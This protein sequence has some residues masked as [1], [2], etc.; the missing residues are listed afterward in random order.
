[1]TIRLFVGGLTNDVSED[2]LHQQ[3]KKFG[4]VTTLDIKEKKDLV[5]DAVIKRFAFVNLDTSDAKIN[6]CEYLLLN[7]N[8]FHDLLHSDFFCIL[9]TSLKIK[10]G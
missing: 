4:I 1:M 3:L 2:D 5:T 7:Y 8:S 9:L 6:E 10:L